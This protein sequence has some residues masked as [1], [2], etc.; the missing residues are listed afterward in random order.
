MQYL[1]IKKKKIQLIILK[2]IHDNNETC[3]STLNCYINNNKN[4][5]Y[6]FLNK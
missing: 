6:C 4:I 1:K 2:V 5:N 3:I